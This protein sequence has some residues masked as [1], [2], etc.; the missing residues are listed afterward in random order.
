M[1]EKLFVFESVNIFDSM[2]VELILVDEF[3]SCFVFSCIFM[4]VFIKLVMEKRV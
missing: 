2:N 1:F 4:V 3:Y